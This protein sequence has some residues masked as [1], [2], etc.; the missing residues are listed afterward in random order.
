VKIMT[1][2][3]NIRNYIGFGKLD[4]N[5]TTFG[6]VMKNAGYTTVRFSAGTP[7]LNAASTLMLPG[8][9]YRPCW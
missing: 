3:D 1:G 8:T 4:K 9:R 5:E 7:A 6:T 2:R